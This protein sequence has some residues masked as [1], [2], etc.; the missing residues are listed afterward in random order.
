MQIQQ[1]ARGLCTRGPC[2]QTDAFDSS[3]IFDSAKSEPS[4][5]SQRRSALVCWQRRRAKSGLKMFIFT[6]TPLLLPPGGSRSQLRTRF[7]D[8]PQRRGVRTVQSSSS[9]SSI[10]LRSTFVWCL[11]VANT[12]NIILLPRGP[13]SRGN[14]VPKHTVF[15]DRTGFVKANTSIMGPRAINTPTDKKKAERISH[16]QRK[17]ST[18]RASIN[19]INTG[20]NMSPGTSAL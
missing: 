2:A 19:L 7:C 10:F 11:I 16:L 9:S 5:A 8:L 4:R 13:L 18:E 6:A 3:T 17:P 15:N 1:L 20:S 14:T 12:E